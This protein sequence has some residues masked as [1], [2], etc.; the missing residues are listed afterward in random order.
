MNILTIGNSFSQDATR[1]IHQLATNQGVSGL[2]VAN[3]YI[4]GCPLSLHFS[5]M[6]DR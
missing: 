5:N 6:K 2:Y 3:L 4:G 1:Y